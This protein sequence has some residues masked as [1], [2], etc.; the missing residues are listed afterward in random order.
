MKKLF[1]ILL[2]FITLISCKKKTPEIKL[3]ALI[4]DHMVLQQNAEVPLWG[5]GTPGAVLDI[6]TDWNVSKSATIGEKGNWFVKISTPKAGGPYTITISSGN[7]IRIIDDVYLGEV[8]L[9]SGQ[10]NMEMPVKGWGKD[11]PV[12]SSAQEIA[13]SDIPQIRMF[14]VKRTMKF[15]PEKD[16]I[17]EWKVSN[18]KNTGDFSATA[19]FFAKNL[20]QNLK[21]PIG[22]IHS[23]WGG[24]PAE[25]WT[26]KKFIKS[27]KGFEGT[28]KQLTESKS[29]QKKM[30]A[31]LKNF[32]EISFDNGL[33]SEFKDKKNDQK[34]ITQGFN[35]SGWKEMMLPAYWE[36]KQ[37]KNFDGI[38]WFRKEF[39]IP[40]GTNLKGLKLYLG[41]VDDM[42]DTFINGKKVGGQLKAGFWDKERIYPVDETILHPGKNIISVKVIDNYGGGGIYGNKK[43]GILNSKNDTVIDL[44]GKWKFL[45]VS[46]IRNGN[47]YHLNEKYSYSSMPKGVI[48][49]NPHFPT[50]LYNGMMAPLIPYTIK[51]AIWYQGESNV[52]RAK[53]YEKLFPTM[54][55]NWRADWK[56]GDFPFYYVQIAPF[57]YNN[58]SPMS[59]AEL[60]NAQFLALKEKNTGM[61][62]TTD[63]GDVDNIHPSNKPEVGKRLALWALKNDYGIDTIICSGPLYKNT[64]FDKKKAIIS[65][66]Y[67]GK[68]LKN[69]GKK[70]RSFEIAGKD[71]VFYNAD[72]KI[73]GKQVIVTS[74]KVKAPKFVRFGWRNDSEPNLFNSAGLPASPFKN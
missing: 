59:A 26:S 38:V 46:L 2:V 11:M 25:A 20:Y 15:T 24:T 70:L 68:G 9:A 28:E 37:L 57:N 22:I 32:K 27:I 35:D 41:K 36:T 1:W 56:L 72:A 3:P 19:Y 66:T 10:S 54:I 60:R 29:G 74:K 31:W 73:N 69:D 55:R 64:R 49:L 71:S 51:G 63:I 47:I 58:G 7:S 18:P 17:G 48:I 65:F 39:N 30:E 62:V 50:V 44:S 6:S 67:T 42:D 8:W 4:S 5:W 12:D 13:A 52:G 21:I 53:Q 61:V 34:Y 33:E 40:K 43:I 16:C 23:S 14:T 45:P